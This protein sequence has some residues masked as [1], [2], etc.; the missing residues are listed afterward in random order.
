M[1][2]K[3]FRDCVHYTALWFNANVRFY[4]KIGKW[5]ERFFNRRSDS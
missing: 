4:D 1:L 5:Q 2:F 3:L